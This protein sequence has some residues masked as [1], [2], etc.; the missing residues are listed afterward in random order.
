MG[1]HLL[2]L[3]SV[4]R[5]LPFF[6]LFRVGFISHL[7]SLLFEFFSAWYLRTEWYFA[8]RL[9]LGGGAPSV[10]HSKFYPALV[11]RSFLTAFLLRA[12]LGP[13]LGSLHFQ[14]RLWDLPVTSHQ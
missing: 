3:M 11:A 6:L 9:P 7:I 14:R 1:H 2:S 8:L 13:W 4:H 12:W 10:R 5:L